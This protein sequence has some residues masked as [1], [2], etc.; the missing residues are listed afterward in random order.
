M[1][2]RPIEPLQ[3]FVNRFTCIWPKMLERYVGVPAGKLENCSDL[4]DKGTQKAI[5]VL[6]K[7]MG[8]SEKQ[9]T[10]AV[11]RGSHN[12][13][14]STAVENMAIATALATLGYAILSDNAEGTK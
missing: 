7:G 10:D 8:L 11:R 9:L 1:T 4:D 3:A 13:S 12:L 6:A 5:R 2:T 14:S